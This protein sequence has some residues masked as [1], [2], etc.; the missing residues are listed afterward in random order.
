MACRYAGWGII[1]DDIIFPD[2][3]TSMGTLGGGGMYAASG[4]RL[5]SEDAALIAAVGADFSADNLTEFGFDPAYIY[6]TPLPTP[7]AWQVLEADGRRTQVHRIADDAWYAQLVFEPS[8]QSIPDSLQAAHWIG[9]GDEQEWD[10]IVALR[11]QGVRLGAEA[12]TYGD[13][14][15]D[16]FAAVRRQLEHVEIFSPDEGDAAKLVGEMSA[17]DQMRAVA[18]LGPRLVALR[19][20]AAGSILFDRDDNTFWKVPAAPAKIGDVTGAGNAYCGGLL[21]GWVESGDVVTAAT[22]AAVSASFVIEQV[23][24]PKIDAKKMEAVRQR[25]AAFREAIVPIAAGE[26]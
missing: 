13:V 16:H 4:M 20:G 9:R 22:Q 17:A 21:V 6:E 10:M 14:S 26:L 18:D 11:A 19:R 2:G 12:I 3:Q 5:W 8:P 23:G 1:V 15:A 25:A 24:P 7:R